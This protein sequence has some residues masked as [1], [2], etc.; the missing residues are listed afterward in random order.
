MTC[1]E[2]ASFMLDYLSG[3][4][5]DEVRLA[6]DYHLSVCPNCVTFL[7]HY[8][9][10]IGAGKIGFGGDPEQQLPETVPDDLVKAILAARLHG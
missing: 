1:R 3:T 6:F 4:L 9:K 5:S 10:T 7:D 2:F 8:Q